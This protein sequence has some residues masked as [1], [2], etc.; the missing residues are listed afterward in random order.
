MRCAP[1][2]DDQNNDLC[3]SQISVFKCRPFKEFPVQSI[4]FVEFQHSVVWVAG[5]LLRYS[6]AS[7]I[8]DTH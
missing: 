8:I 2:Q 4:T 5:T 3:F 6:L 1:Y 7:T